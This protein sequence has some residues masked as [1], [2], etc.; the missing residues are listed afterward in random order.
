MDVFNSVI[1][2]QYTGT[3]KGIRTVT[4]EMLIDFEHHKVRGDVVV[5]YHGEK[6]RFRCESYAE[7]G[8]WY[9]LCKAWAEGDDDHADVIWG[10]GSDA[11]ENQ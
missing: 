3:V 10:E 2:R 8:D 11:D 6:K 7:A 9:E 1:T 4:L 5:R